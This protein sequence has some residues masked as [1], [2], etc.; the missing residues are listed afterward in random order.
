MNDFNKVK[1]ELEGK[2]KAFNQV[3][4]ELNE[5]KQKLA[6]SV[7]ESAKAKQELTDTANKNQT[8]QS[9][10]TQL[11]ALA[12]KYR[13]ES[14]KFK[15]SANET[16][17]KECQ[18]DIREQPTKMLDVES[19]LR[20]KLEQNNELMNNFKKI[21]EEN[22]VF[23]KQAI[24]KDEKAK[25]IAQQ[26]K[27]RISD[28][29]VATESLTLEKG[30]LTKENNELKSRISQ[31]EGSVEQN[32]LTIAMLKSQYETKLN[33]QTKELQAANKQIGDLTSKLQQQPPSSTSVTSQSSTVPL[34][35]T[36]IPVGIATNITSST[37][38][39][40]HSVHP[41][42]VSTSASS[43][44]AAKTTPT[45]SIKPLTVAA[46]R[47]PPTR[48]TQVLAMIQPTATEESLNPPAVPQATVQPTSLSTPSS[49][50]ISSTIPEFSGAYSAGFDISQPSTSSQPPQGFD[51]K[52][53]FESTLD[54]PSSSM[55]TKKMKNDVELITL[56]NEDEESDVEFD[57]DAKV[58]SDVVNTNAE[59]SISPAFRRGEQSDENQIGSAPES[60]LDDDREEADDE[61]NNEEED[62]DEDV[63]EEKPGAYDE[64]ED[65]D[66][67]PEEFDDDIQE[68]SDLECMD[69]NEGE[70]LDEEDEEEDEGEDEE[71][72][73]NQIRDSSEIEVIA[74]DDSDEEHEAEHGDPGP[75]SATRDEV[76]SS[77][78]QSSSQKGSY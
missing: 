52:R 38:P 29:K 61:L 51:K 63:D 10:I 71:E 31:L 5:V 62:F 37:A 64:E 14:V 18:C 67:E 28:L 70:E 60:G 73:D 45:A 42:S 34:T 33:S 68:E 23:K 20:E 3:N 17:D 72:E 24:E 74:I 25:K 58:E 12:R 4:L 66:E 43:I 59:D 7:E 57:V 55:T 65:I 76:S 36:V 40:R 47:P 50:S 6:S 26:A 39:T 44:Q 46:T 41:Q 21:S 48:P 11:K 30:Q 13:D 16:F 69:E 53:P 15:S 22:E 32:S 75:S 19:K 2:I 35:T 27:Q 56:A 1:S 78:V 8:L 49:T 54:E 9:T 77:N